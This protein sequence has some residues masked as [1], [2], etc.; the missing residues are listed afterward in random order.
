[1]WTKTIEWENKKVQITMA[2]IW[3]AVARAISNSLF[4]EV[5][6]HHLLLERPG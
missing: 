6:F 4:G 3:E 5:Q 2:V 1:M